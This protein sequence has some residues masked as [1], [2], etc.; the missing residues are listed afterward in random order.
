MNQQAGI[1]PAELAF[2]IDG[3]VADTMA[4]FVT[5]G[6]ERYGLTHLTKDHLSCYNLYKCLD[7]DKELLDELICLTLDDEHT[8]VIPPMPGAPEVLTELAAYGPLRFVTARIWPE[9]IIRWLHATLPDVPPD[10]IQVIATGAP[11]AKVNI[12]RDL[13]VNY[14][15]E[16]RLETCRLLARDGFSPLLFDQPW[17]RVPEDEGFPRLENWGEVR[18][19]VLPQNE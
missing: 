17:N 6:R 18:Q 15:L 16:D 13:Q 5:L 3:V 11:E 14:F 7:L 1:N 10:R 4:L 12:L 19:L 9:S 8:A 2:D